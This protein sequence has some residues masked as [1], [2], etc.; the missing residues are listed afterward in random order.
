MGSP[1]QMELLLNMEQR[2][3]DDQIDIYEKLSI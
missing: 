2:N 3:Y 1:Q